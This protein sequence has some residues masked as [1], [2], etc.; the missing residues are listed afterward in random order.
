MNDHIDLRHLR[1]FVAVAEELH[2]RRA[3]ERLHLAQPALS[4]AIQWLEAELGAP[5]FVRTTRNVTLTEAGRAFLDE[6]RQALKQFDKAVGLARSAAA[7]HVGDLTVA[8]MDFAINGALPGILKDFRARCPGIRVALL[9]MWTEKQRQAILAN[10][11]DIGFLIGP[12]VGPEVASL[13]VRSERFVV[14]LPESHPLSAKRSIALGDLADEPFILGSSE[15]WGP[16][17]RKIDE[18]CDSAGFA[19]HVVQ[20]AYNSDGIFGL[21][22]ADMGLTIYVEGA[23][24]RGASGV[25]I[26]P[27]AGVD[28]RLETVAAWRKGNASPAIGRFIDVVRAYAARKS[29]K[30]LTSRAATTPPGR[31]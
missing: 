26:R 30:S 9:H 15:F 23:R 16:Y 3:A 8:Y 6:S 11:I 28:A 24:D 20:E 4:R 29:R 14:V 18:L 5:L 17:R 10:D 2:F 27:L 21:I 31:A 7:G 1:C 25:A 12:F 13:V 19:P 22:A